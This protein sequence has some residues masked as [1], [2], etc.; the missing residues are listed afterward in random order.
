[1]VSCEKET[2]SPESGAPELAAASGHQ[3][4]LPQNPCGTSTVLDIIDGGGNT[5]G[6]IE[7]MNDRFNNYAYIR[8]AQGWFIDQYQLFMGPSNTV[9]LN[10]ALTKLNME[11]F[12]YQVDFNQPV[13]AELVSIPHGANNCNEVIIWMR[14]VK[15]NFF[16][17]VILT[18]EGWMDGD[19]LYQGFSSEFCS[20]ACI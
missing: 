15:L 16:G 11:K 5:F 3:I 1:M 19:A 20:N 6:V 2:L 18:K 7:L 13:N 14:L 10:D 8:P 9:P 4:N 12:P 17:S